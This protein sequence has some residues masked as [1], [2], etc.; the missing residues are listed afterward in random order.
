MDKDFF[1][2][3]MKWLRADFHLHTKADK[4]FQYSDSDSD[5]YRLYVERLE[6][7]GVSIGVVTNHNKFD[8]EEYRKLR[9]EASKKNIWLLPGVELS[10]NDGSNGVHCLI[11]F[12][13]DKWL[14]TDDDFINQ[15]LTSVFE[16]VA[17]RENENVSCNH[18]LETVLNKLDAHRKGGRD[19]FVILAHVNQG[20]G[21]F[22]ELDGGRIQTIA[23][24]EIFKKSVL[25]FQKLTNRD[26]ESNCKTWLRGWMPAKVQ[27]SDCKSIGS[28][29]KAQVL[30][31][32]DLKTYI[33][34]G[35]FNFDALKYALMDKDHRVAEESQTT[36]KS[37]LKSISFSGGKL[38]GQTITFSPE[39]NNFIGIRGSG[40]SSVL[41]II[42]Y[43][44]GIELTDAAADKKYKNELVSYILGSGGKAT[45]EFHGID[46]KNYRIEKILNQTSSLYSETDEFLECSLNAVIDVPMYFGQKDL[47][48]KKDS[49]ES[50]LINRMIGSHLDE[51]R[52]VVTGQEQNVRNCLI[53]LQKLGSFTD[54]IPELEKTIKDALQKLTFYKENGVEEKLRIQTQYEHDINI[55]NT[56]IGK[57]V[58]FKNS[59]SE[60]LSNKDLW[61]EIKGSEV[62][63]D[64]FDSVNSLLGEGKIISDAITN[65]VRKFDILL[66][67]LNNE[68]NRLNTKVDSMKEEFAKIKRELNSDTVNPD[69]FLKINRLLSESKQKLTELKDVEKKREQL[70]SNLLTALDSLNEAWRKEFLALETSVNRIN[71]SSANLKIE[72]GFKGRRN[73]FAA[74]FKNLVRGSSLRE[75]TIQRVV[76]KYNDYI[77][78]YKNWD[79]FKKLIAESAFSYVSDRINKDLADL[80]TYKVGNKVTIKYKG[81]DLSRHSLGQRASALILFLLAQKETGILIIDQPEDDLDNQTIYDEVIKEIV[82]LKT[83]MQFIFATHNANIPVLGDSEKVVACNFEDSSKI[84]IVEGSI[85]TPAIQKSIVSI[86]EGG[87]EAFNRRKDIYNI[88]R[89]K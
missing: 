52:R 58:E 31:D 11:V 30:G 86:M 41:E 33:K 6:A 56:K 18:N 8:R 54:R 14:G 63:V 39:L 78:I 83:D 47:S 76:E 26:T 27:G 1:N 44:L 46:G 43:V 59:L 79:D 36:A 84:E 32:K 67:K 25:G 49:F 81:K 3:G 38:D 65:E 35:D 23:N 4:E 5:F 7:E 21:F 2:F 10:V 64:I 57:V 70:R 40:K 37:Y 82:K 42:R 20:K 68:L 13:K 75:T 22:N 19:S 50:E 60:A 55:L 24:K 74:H 16:G 17:N 12:D 53:E 51:Q 29:G 9:K 89:I 71:L 85:D 15:F 88:W 77:E 62:S 87:E 34:I 45:L 72:V 80:L 69:E 73:D 66:E 61:A 28:V 48:N